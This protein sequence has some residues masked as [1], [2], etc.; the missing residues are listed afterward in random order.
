MDWSYL[1]AAGGKEGFRERIWVHSPSTQSATVGIAVNTTPTSY[2]STEVMCVIDN[3]ANVN[4]ASGQNVWVIPVSIDLVVTGGSTGT[5]WAVRLQ[6]DNATS[7]VS[8]GTTCNAVLTSFDTRSGYADRTPYGRV[9]F[10]DVTAGGTANRKTIGE[11]SISLGSSALTVGSHVHLAFGSSMPGG[12]G[13]LDRTSGTAAVVGVQD[14]VKS[15]P[16]VSIG[17]GSSLL[18]QPFASTATDLSFRVA[19]TCLEVGHP[20]ES[21]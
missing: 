19:V 2:T 6:M 1:L 17:R 16:L 21:V 5:F 11:Y 18:I 12:N 3:T 14:V 9:Y 13:S 20:R 15:F 4:A 10:G 8:G 7:Y